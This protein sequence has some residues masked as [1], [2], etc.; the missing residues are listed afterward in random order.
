MQSDRRGSVAR[1]RA[2]HVTMG[3]MSDKPAP[4]LVVTGPSGAG[5]TTVGRLVAAA[6]DLSAHVQVDDFMPFV[7]NGWVEPWR[8]EAVRQNHVLGGAIAAAALEFA[9]GGYTVVLD[10]AIFPEGLGGLTPWSA[11]R[12]VP[13]HY[14]VLRPDLATCLTRVRQRRSGDPDDLKSFTQLHARFADLGDREAN[15]I[16]TAGTPED[17]AATVLAAFSSG[18]LN[19][20]TPPPGPDGQDADADAGGTART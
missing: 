9:A 2:P 4:I 18:R 17:V 1:G 16:E 13:L 3:L 11:R 6:F 7:V 10:G 20:V 19:V 8:P 12:A 14:A 15:V 5:K